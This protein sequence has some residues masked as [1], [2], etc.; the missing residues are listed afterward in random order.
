MQRVQAASVDAP[1]T[2]V[3]QSNGAIVAAGV[4]VTGV[5]PPSIFNGNPTEFGL[6]RFQSNGSIDTTFGTR[7]GIIPGFPNFN[8]GGVAT[9]ALQI[10][11]DVVAAGQAAFS[12]PN[13]N[14]VSSSFALARYFSSGQLDNT[15]GTG[16]L[17]THSFGTT[18]SAFIA[19]RAIQT[20]G[21]I[22]AAGPTG[23][24][25]GNIAAARYLA[26]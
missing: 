21:K 17:V 6:M 15:F 16:G 8:F 9:I 22:V 7:G 3:V 26:Q 12:S 25:N 18:N 5:A 14:Q 4:S 23:D 13:Q 19:A 24:A 1:A 20:D 11:G 2:L 10:N